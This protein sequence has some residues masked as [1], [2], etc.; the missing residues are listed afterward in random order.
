MSKHHYAEELSW[1][2][3]QVYY[4][5]PPESDAYAPVISNSINSNLHIVDY[6][7]HVKGERFIPAIFLNSIRKMQAEKIL[8]SIGGKVD[9][10]WSFFPNQFFDLKVFGKTYKI[11][12]PVDKIEEER[13]IKTAKSADVVLS[14]A[15]YL[16]KDFRPYNSNCHFINHGLSK[17]YENVVPE[18]SK[19]FGKKV[20]VGY[21]G[22]FLRPDIDHA[23]FL[24]IIEENP[25]IEFVLWGSNKYEH[26]DWKHSGQKEVIEFIK[27]LEQ[28]SNVI[29]KGLVHPEVVARETKEM[30]VFLCCYDPMREINRASNNHKLM[31]YLSSGKIVVSHFVETYA[32]KSHLLRMSESYSNE[33]LPSIFKEVLSALDYWNSKQRMEERINFANDN[34]YSKQISRIE[35]LL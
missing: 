25:N 1:R 21:V 7:T 13:Y 32:D 5:N 15:E 3:N 33:N 29:L 4:L 20:R 14:V 35:K 9:I 26:L 12:H 23:T 31:E 34:T 16:L 22:N 6:N 10:V 24:K 27:K 2:D 30:D 19:D 17:T 18:Y 28:L 8:K 11:F